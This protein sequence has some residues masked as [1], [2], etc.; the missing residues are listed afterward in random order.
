[1]RLTLAGDAVAQLGQVAGVGRE[2][3][4]DV[5]R[6]AQANQVVDEV[7]PDAPHETANGGVAPSGQVLEHVLLDQSATCAAS[8]EG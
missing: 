2:A 8:R 1:M 7:R 4:A 6:L 5:V 3:A